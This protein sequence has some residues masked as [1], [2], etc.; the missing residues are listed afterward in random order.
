MT[1]LQE[2][3]AGMM[4]RHVRSSL[5][6]RLLPTK[7]WPRPNLDLIKAT[8]YLNHKYFNGTLTG[9]NLLWVGDNNMAH[10]FG[11]RSSRD[12]RFDYKKSP[13]CPYRWTLP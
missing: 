11:T 8:P 9:V 3:F 6:S 4:A 10:A 5:K 2:S 13:V 12:A 1:A 7:I